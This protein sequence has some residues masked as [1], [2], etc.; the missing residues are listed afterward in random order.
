MEDPDDQTLVQRVLRGDAACFGTLCTR[1]Y[2]SLVATADS[3]LFDH[4]LAEE[5]A[6]EALA[7]ACRRLPSLKRPASF[8]PWVGAIAS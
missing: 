6:Q 4:H 5:A 2:P 8:G 3:I 1:H 7:E